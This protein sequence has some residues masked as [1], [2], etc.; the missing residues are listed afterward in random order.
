M[1][2][3]HGPLSGVL[4]LHIQKAVPEQVQ[5]WVGHISTPADMKPLRFLGP[6]KLIQPQQFFCLVAC[7]LVPQILSFEL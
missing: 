6:V 1:T 4:L 3:C 5:K 7:P 2:D